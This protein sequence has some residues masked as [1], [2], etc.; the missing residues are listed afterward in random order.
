MHQRLSVND[1][2]G[3]LIHIVEQLDAPPDNLVTNVTDIIQLEST[4]P[5]ASDAGEV[6]EFD[7]GVSTHDLLRVGCVIHHWTRVDVVASTFAEAQDIAA[8]MAACGGWMPT[9]TVFVM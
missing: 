9:I 3:G 5:E 7:V 6:W 1:V 4:S 2:I 8:A